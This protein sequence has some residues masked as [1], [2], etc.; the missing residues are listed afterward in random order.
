MSL[1]GQ[2]SETKEHKFIIIVPLKVFGKSNE[3]LVIYCVYVLF[4]GKLETIIGSI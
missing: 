3:K 2:T 1:A 4:A